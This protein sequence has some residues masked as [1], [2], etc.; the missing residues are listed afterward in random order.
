MNQKHQEIQDL[1]NKLGIQGTESINTSLSLGN[2]DGYFVSDFS[3][4][5]GTLS[6]GQ[7][8]ECDEA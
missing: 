3:K 2:M 7:K 8:I 6:Q 5:Q 1:Y 4:M